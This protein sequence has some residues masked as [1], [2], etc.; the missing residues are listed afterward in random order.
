MNS[1]VIM[2]TQT[3][4][5][6]C[7]ATKACIDH[8]HVTGEIRALLCNLCNVSIGAMRESPKIARAAA[9]YLEHYGTQ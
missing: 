3:Y 5:R 2:E 8:N 6:G 7:V 1:G 9:E 4:Q